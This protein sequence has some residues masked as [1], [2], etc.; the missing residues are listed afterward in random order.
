MLNDIFISG[1]IPA[2]A[3][4]G[5]YIPFLVLL[6]YII[7]SF[8]SYTGI[9]L[10]C[11][12]YRAQ[13]RLQKNIIHLGGA[14]ALGAGIWS[15]HFVGMLSYSTD[16]LHTYDTTLTAISMMMAVLAAFGAIA[17]ARA[18]LFQKELVAV[19][20]LLMGTAICVMHYTGMAAMEMD[21]DF[22]YIPSLF[23][24][25]VFIAIVASGAAI[26]IIYYLGTQK[27]RSLLLFKICAAMTMGLAICGMHYTGMA[28]LV[29]IPWANCRTGTHQDFTTL[30]IA[31]SAFTALIFLIYTF[32]N[33]WLQRFDRKKMQNS[34]LVKTQEMEKQTMLLNTLLDNMPLSIFAKD[35]KDDFKFIML[36]KMA[37]ET[38]GVKKEDTIGKSDYDFFPKSDADFF[39]ATDQN[40][41][42]S[43]KVVD[44]EAE[45]VTTAKGSFIAH[46]IKIPIYDENGDPHILLGI[47]ED[48]TEK[49]KTQ[50]QLIIAKEQAENANLAKSEFLAN[51][52]HEIRTPMNGII[53]LTRLLAESNLDIDQEQSVQAVLKS[54]ESLLYLLN[55][56]L[57]FSKIEAGELT[58]EKTSFNL[59]GALRNVID[60][61]SPIA[62]KK[63]LVLNYH[64]DENTPTSVIG[65]TTRICQ[66]VTNLVGNAVK[67][68]EQGHITLSV[69]AEKSSTDPEGYMYHFAIEDTGVGIPSNMHS[70]IFRK[71]SQVDESTTR[72][73]GGTGLGLAICESL[74]EMMGGKIFFT[75]E[76]GKGSVFKIMLPLKKSETEISEDSNVRASIQ[77]MSTKRDFSRSRILVVDDHP[78]NMMFTRKLLQK[79][80]FT[81]VDE[82]SNGVEAL[83]RLSEA[84]KDYDLILMDCQMPEMDGFEACRRIRLGENDDHRI[85]IIAMTAGAMEGDREKCLQSGMDDYISKP[86]N[87]DKLHA[88]LSQWLSST[89]SGDD[90]PTEDSVPVKKPVVDLSHLELFTD[91]DLNQ[92]SMITKAYFRGSE[93]AINALRAH[94]D[95]ANSD[96]DWKMAAHKLKGSSAQIGA[97]ILAASCLAAEKAFDQTRHEKIDILAII[98]RDYKK[99]ADFFGSRQKGA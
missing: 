2:D 99:V 35:A 95:R 8:G 4:K 79:M 46:T 24:L 26:G 20:A 33:T 47:L 48:V 93:D 77:N 78:V 62:S 1:A 15:M 11:D 25:S 43:R 21:A 98:E 50:E 23:I 59:K 58:L 91:G 60:L 13:S 97:N 9:S 84:K 96:E 64:F 71:F 49:I 39:R 34:L 52:S 61:L 67:F 65:D 74:T 70:H 42:L 22:R 36:N 12:I 45:T 32:R 57:D 89:E 55:D 80:G 6:S 88:V 14:V 30:V 44:I 10:A 31:I 54:S 51:M 73:F 82:A 69:G 40:V 41:V 92:E 83:E 56:I 85:T 27:G 28:A 16:M 38:F 5:T 3:V 86:V 19:S 17:A 68:T 37:E 72:K 90:V 75:S 63:G 81:R 29:I 94:I 87:P 53:G 76:L 7:A 66:I 18:A